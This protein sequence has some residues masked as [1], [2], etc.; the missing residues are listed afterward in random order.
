MEN[1]ETCFTVAS[2]ESLV[3]INLKTASMYD[4]YFH[5]RLFKTFV[6]MLYFESRKLS[7]LQQLSDLVSDWYS[8]AMETLL[9]LCGVQLFWRDQ[10]GGR[11]EIFVYLRGCFGTGFV[12]GGKLWKQENR[13]SQTYKPDSSHSNWHWLTKHRNIHVLAL[14]GT[15]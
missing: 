1:S 7:K 3:P 6:K 11:D 5:T 13:D 14:H 15:M 2:T 10:K 12:M 8:S 4:N 9:H